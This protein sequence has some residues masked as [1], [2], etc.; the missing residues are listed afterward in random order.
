MAVDV[1]TLRPYLQDFDLT[2]LMVEGLGWNH[3]SGEP[4]TVVAGSETYDLQPVAEKADFPV[5]RC[6]ANPDGAVP[7]QST[8]RQIERQV[9]RTHYEHL[10]VFV[11]AAQDRQVWQWV[12]RESGKPP[13]L[14]ELNYVKGQ[15]GAALLQRLRGIEFTLQEEGNLGHHRRD[16]EVPAILGRRARH[17]ALL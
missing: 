10:I 12:K 9:A 2:S 1:Q 3:L 8:R 6:S 15:T 16:R 14:R 17:Q 11:D 4:I 7:P 13:A 5:Y